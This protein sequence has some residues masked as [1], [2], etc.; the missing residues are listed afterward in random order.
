MMLSGCTQYAA[1]PAALPRGTVA[2]VV[3]T[4]TSVPVLYTSSR[5]AALDLRSNDSLES[6][7]GVGES[8]TF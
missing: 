6:V 3:S 7:G 5:S 8:L 1:L 2:N 4:S